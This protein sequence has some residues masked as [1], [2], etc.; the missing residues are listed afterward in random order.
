MNQPVVAA[1]LVLVFGM[2]TLGCARTPDS[3]ADLPTVA[4][5]DLKRWEG[6]WYELARI[7][8]P[9][10]RDWV[11]TVETYTP[12][13]DGTYSVVY[14]G[15][16]GSPQGARKALKQR[17]RIPDPARPGEMQVSFL[18]LVWLDYR[19]IHMEDD[20]RFMLVTGSSRDYLWIMGREPKPAPEVYARLV[21]KAAAMGFDTSRLERV[22]QD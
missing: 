11:D 7:P 16:K 20:Y 8:V 6:P 5:L 17:L 14:E 21:A 1:A 12:R 15:H 18:P 3:T 13:G 10:G 22:R 2:A 19:L 9:I 4:N